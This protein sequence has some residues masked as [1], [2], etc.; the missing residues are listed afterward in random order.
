M[1]KLPII[2]HNDNKLQLVQSIEKEQNNLSLRKKLAEE[3]SLTSIGEFIEGRA[4]VHKD[5][6]RRVMNKQ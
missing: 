4:V 5:N 6:K 1:N 3:H 2:S